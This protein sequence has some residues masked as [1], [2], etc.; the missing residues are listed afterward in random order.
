MVVVGC[1]ARLA[2]FNLFPLAVVI[3]GETKFTNRHKRSPKE[4]REF[5]VAL[6]DAP[7]SVV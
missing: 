7:S 5:A 2:R 4:L 1:C 6:Y 3:A